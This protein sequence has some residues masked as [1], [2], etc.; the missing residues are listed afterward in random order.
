MFFIRK[1]LFIAGCCLAP[2]FVAECKLPELS[3]ATVTTKINEIMKAHASHK[4]L[5]PVIIERTLT[6]YLELLDPNKSYF[7]ESDIHPWLHPSEQ[8]L[9]KS[10]KI[11]IEITFVLSNKYIRSWR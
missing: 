11:I 10:S 4:S 8:L 2:F 5:T 9:I 1:V 6:N 3:P 7:I